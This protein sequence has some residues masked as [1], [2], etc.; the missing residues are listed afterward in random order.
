MKKYKVLKRILLGFMDPQDQ[1]EAFFLPSHV[2]HLE[3]E[4]STIYV[5]TTSGNRLE[6]ITTTNIIG[7]KDMIGFWFP[8]CGGAINRMDKS[9][10]L[11]LFYNNIL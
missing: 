7:K 6:S 11:L 4:N 9:C 5:I 8:P 1:Y 3:T 2:S 10:I